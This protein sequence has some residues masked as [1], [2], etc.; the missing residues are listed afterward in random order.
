LNLGNKVRLIA[1]TLE[2]R[3]DSPGLLKRYVT[4]RGVRP[5]S[6]AM[7]IK[8]DPDTHQD[9]LEELGIPVGYN[10]CWVNS[11]GI[12]A[13]LLDKDHRIVRKY[14]SLFWNTSVLIA[15]FTSL[16]NEGEGE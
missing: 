12:E 3:H 1:I 7:A 4:G 11:H 14:S 10:S 13:V 15:D 9:L 8:L 16:L 2:P 6:G 5:R